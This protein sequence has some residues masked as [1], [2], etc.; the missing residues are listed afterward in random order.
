M[1]RS[2]VADMDRLGP[3]LRQLLAEAVRNAT[4]THNPAYGRALAV[5]EI[6]T[7]IEHEL[8]DPRYSPAERRSFRQVILEAMSHGRR[9]T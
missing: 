7:V 9:M 3:D 6:L 5:E 1:V 4:H 8:A 2:I